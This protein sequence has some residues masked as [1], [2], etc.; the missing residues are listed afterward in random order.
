MNETILKYL[1]AL[2]NGEIISESQL[3]QSVSTNVDFINFC[4]VGIILKQKKGAGQVYFLNL[5][6]KS[7]FN[8]Y[9]EKTFPNT[10]IEEITKASNIAKFKNSKS[11][12]IEAIPIVFLRGVGSAIING[13]LVDLEYY[14]SKF[15][16]FASTLES[17]E[18][19]KLCIVENKYLFL[20]IEK[21]ISNDFIFLHSYGRIGGSLLKSLLCNE[22]LIVSDY[23]YVGLNEFLKC[24][25]HNKNT[26]L[27]IPDNFN[28]LFDTYATNLKKKNKKGQLLKN[29]PRVANSTDVTVAEIRERIKLS[30]K[31]LEQEIL[32]YECKR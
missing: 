14:T 23:D 19:K 4:R 12:Q 28:Y 15:S 8:K 17:L 27:F 30:Q 25:E 9:F 31:F 7:I 5:E 2:K 18:T 29:Y 16:L 6:K 24:K 20:E 21:V 1:T 3:P 11:R 10:E 32:L 13:N 26:Q 22:I